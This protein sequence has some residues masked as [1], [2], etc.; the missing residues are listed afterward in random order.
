MPESS[1]FSDAERSLFS[2]AQIQHLMRV[3]FNRAG[4][5]SYPIVC[6]IIAI[7]RLGTCATSTATRPKRSSWRASSR[8]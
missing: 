8:C 4:R 2:L 6:M 7:D 1:A 5:Y 3:E